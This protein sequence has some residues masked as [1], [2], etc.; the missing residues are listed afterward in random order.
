MAGSPAPCNFC[1]VWCRRVRRLL[2]RLLRSWI[3]GRSILRRWRSILRRWRSILRTW[4]SILRRWRSI[5]RR[6]PGWRNGG[7]GRS[8]ILY[9][10]SWLL[11]RA[12]LLRLEA[13]TLGDKPLRSKSLGPR[14]LCRPVIIRGTPP[15]FLLS[16]PQVSVG[17]SLS[18]RTSQPP[19]RKTETQR[20]E[21]TSQSIA[22]ASLKVY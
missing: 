12:D 8:A 4:R 17:R 22:H 10:W 2:R 14:A 3:R 9:S 11:R 15:L 21:E 13:G 19:T 7:R 1:R 6:L 20:G 18:D 16:T 5:L